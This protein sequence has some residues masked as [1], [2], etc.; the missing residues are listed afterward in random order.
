MSTSAVNK[1]L[2][3]YDETYSG[4]VIFIESNPDP[5]REGVIWSVSK[6]D[7]ECSEGMEFSV[8]AALEAA[9]NSIDLKLK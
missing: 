8:E 9:R 2:K 1:H 3:T 6:D 5:Y 4:H 7:V